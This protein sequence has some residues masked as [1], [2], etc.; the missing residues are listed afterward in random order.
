VTSWIVFAAAD[1]VTLLDYFQRGGICM[2]PLVLCSLI[3]LTI[4]V[5]KAIYFRGIRL[6]GVEFAAALAQRIRE[7]GRTEAAIMAAAEKS[8]V[9]LV[10]RAGLEGANGSAGKTRE[11][12][13][14]C[15]RLQVS[16][17]EQYL[18]LLSTVA[19]IAPLLGFLGTVTG[20]INAFEQISLTNEVTPRLVAAGVSEALITTAFGLMIAIPTYAAYNLFVARVASIENDIETVTSHVIA[21]LHPEALSVAA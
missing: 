20:M 15:A 18:S 3:G 12:M 11:A 9:A 14:E 10:A 1:R 17:V 5:Y 2:Y 21:E 7:R 13:D 16:R 6:E 19:Y 8:P 4:I